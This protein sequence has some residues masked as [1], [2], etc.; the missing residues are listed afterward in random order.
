MLMRDRKKIS[1]SLILSSKVFPGLWFTGVAG[2]SVLFVYHANP[3][4]GMVLTLVPP[5]M[6]VIG[7][8]AFRKAYGDLVQAYDEGDA[9][10]FYKK[11]Q[12]QRVKL[13]DISNIS[14]THMTS[15]ERI[16]IHT[17]YAG[18][19][20]KELA[21]CPLNRWFPFTQSPVASDLISRVDRARR[22][23]NIKLD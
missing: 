9:L 8:R 11:G 17:R 23:C 20:G 7:Y 19:L 18:P 2:M 4:V 12:R 16:T 3:G 22:G 15:P 14:Y 13:E 6:L 1:K 21:F 5:L 10:V